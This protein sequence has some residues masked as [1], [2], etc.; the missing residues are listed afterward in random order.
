VGRREHPELPAA[1]RD[2]GEARRVLLTA[3]ALV[4]GAPFWFDLLGTFARLRST[5][6]RVGTEKDDSLAPSDRD[7][8]LK[9]APA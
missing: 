3:F 6:N 4:L 9:R 8:R 1:R 5:G 2:R 7:D